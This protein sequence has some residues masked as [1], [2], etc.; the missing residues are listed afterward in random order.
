MNKNTIRQRRHDANLS[1]EELAR[2]CNISRQF[3]GMIEL[4]KSVPTIHIAVRIAC[5][6][7]CDVY[8]LW[9]TLGEPE[10]A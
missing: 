7:D 10:A 9:P 5:E 2:R 4:D 3:L 1:Q 6:L 8:D